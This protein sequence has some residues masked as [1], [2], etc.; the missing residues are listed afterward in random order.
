MPLALFH[1]DIM[2]SAPWRAGITVHALSSEQEVQSRSNKQIRNAME[3]GGGSSKAAAGNRD[4]IN[5]KRR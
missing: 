1:G 2:H 4:L 3:G 5:K